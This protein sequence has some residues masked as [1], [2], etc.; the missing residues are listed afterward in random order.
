MIPAKVRF[1]GLEFDPLDVVDRWHRGVIPP[2][3]HRH[4]YTIPATDQSPISALNR[5][6][7][8]NI[9]G[10]WSIWMRYVKNNREVNI[11]FENDYDGVLFVLADAKVE[12][13]KDSEPVY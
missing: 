1:T 10:R 3:W 9:A 13:L 4:R 5:W 11:A 6:L 8:N 7:Y 2:E 12:A